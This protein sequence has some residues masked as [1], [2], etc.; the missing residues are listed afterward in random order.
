MRN[1]SPDYERRKA[2]FDRCLTIY[3]RKSVLEALQCPGVICERLH[4]AESNRAAE[5]IDTIIELATEQGA[6]VRHHSR[7]ALARISRNARE[8]QGVAADLRW[9]GYRQLDELL[10]EPAAGVLLAID[11]VSNPQNLGMLIRSAAA[12]GVRG[13]LLPRRGGCDIGPLVIKASA[14]SLFRAPLLRC[15]DLPDALMQLRASG[16]RIATLAADASASLFDLSD[17][18]PRVFVLGGE[19]HGVSVEVAA[20]ADE[21]LC[22]PMANGVESL[23]VAVTA[24]LVGYHAT[25]A[26]R[27][28]SG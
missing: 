27:G 9:T 20:L 6:S 12:A 7:E 21:R 1:D 17:S 25:R 13:V 5:I 22:I 26:G 8:D 18:R 23:N 2:A 4:L 16:W 15:A 28:L 14:G 11:G 3:G 10:E 19:T 24:A